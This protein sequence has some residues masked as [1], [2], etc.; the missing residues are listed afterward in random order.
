MHSTPSAGAVAN[1]SSI[2]LQATLN[3]VPVEEADD[4]ESRT[5]KS[6]LVGEKLLCYAYLILPMHVVNKGQAR[7]FQKSLPK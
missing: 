6:Q 3:D 5:C 7:L 2:V 1:N 4:F